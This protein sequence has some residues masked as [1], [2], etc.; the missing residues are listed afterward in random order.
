MHY[1]WLC[2]WVEWDSLGA[3]VEG[4]VEGEFIRVGP[5]LSEIEA[6][7]YIADGCPRLQEA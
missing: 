3:Y 4:Y 5:F 2:V 1:M 6:R 7:K